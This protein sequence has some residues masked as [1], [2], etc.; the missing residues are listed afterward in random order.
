MTKER[1]VEKRGA[2]SRDK[3]VIGAARTFSIGHRRG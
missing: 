3:A 2:L 1:V